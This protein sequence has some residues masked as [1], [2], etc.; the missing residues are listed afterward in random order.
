MDRTN[1][2]T[3]LGSKGGA[4]PYIELLVGKEKGRHFELARAQV[5]IGRSE[6]SDILFASDA[7]SRIHAYLTKDGNGGWRIRDNQSK[8]GV[9][10]N[11]SKTNEQVLRSGDLVQVGDFV[12]RFVDPSVK[13]AP[14]GAE[15]KVNLSEAAAF[16]ALRKAPS[17]VWIACAV[18]VGI[19]FLF[20]SPSLVKKVPVEK[21]ESVVSAVRS[22][23]AP[24]PVVTVQN[25]PTVPTKVLEQAVAP[26]PAESKAAPPVTMAD[27]TGVRPMT[28]QDLQIK[29]KNRAK[30]VE[31]GKSLK[32]Y[33]EEGQH[34]LSQ[35][36]YESA[37]IAF[38]FAILIDPRNT[39]AIAG[40]EAAQA[41]A[42]STA[43]AAQTASPD[44]GLAGRQ[45]QSLAP[46]VP[47]KDAGP[48][49]DDKKE[50]VQ[51]LMEKANAAFLAKKYQLAIDTAEAVRAIEI[52]GQ[53]AY[54]NEA[55]QVIDRAK[56]KQK[57][58]FEPF[59]K[60]ANSLIDEGS[61]R[62]AREICDQMLQQD[63]AYTPAKDCRTRADKLMAEESQ[64]K[65]GGER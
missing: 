29:T 30:K 47:V 12:F 56:M 59:L 37:S 61:Y 22:E 8:N 41:G 34:Y 7:V 48:T 42:R 5:S 26:V 3:L 33:L 20:L 21:T 38:N 40:M 2:L 39:Q 36:D 45:A 16:T 60:Q 17:P 54:L 4:Q 52:K 63:D 28:R 15:R 51:G 19:L 14:K 49:E 6:E 18:L 44:K 62:T 9:Q 23:K 64:A 57:E 27:G 31:A 58:D 53:T 50:Q 13:K 43:S 1:T 65:A 24:E 25:E 35:G 32:I 46:P 11:G 55:K 10:V